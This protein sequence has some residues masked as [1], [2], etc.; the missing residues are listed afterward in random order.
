MSNVL[1]KINVTDEEKD[2]MKLSVLGSAHLAPS[3]LLGQ[4]GS[5]RTILEVE[6]REGSRGGGR[7]R[8]SSSPSWFHAS[9]SHQHNKV[10]AG[11]AAQSTRP[12]A[13]F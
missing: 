1:P 11:E 9:A 10:W 7:G 5:L 2:T 4:D 8:M 6:K 13:G 3:E 12:K